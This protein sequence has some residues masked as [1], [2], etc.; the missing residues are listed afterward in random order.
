MIFMVAEFVNDSYIAI[1]LN[2]RLLNY[3]FLLAIFLGV[4]LI[5]PKFYIAITVS[6]FLYLVGVVLICLS[7]NFMVSQYCPGI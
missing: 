2:N 7:Q 6:N 1:D 3:S 4:R 5:I